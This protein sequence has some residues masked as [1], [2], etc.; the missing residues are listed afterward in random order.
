MATQI[1]YHHLVGLVGAFLTVYFY[2]GGFI[3]IELFMSPVSDDNLYISDH[4][5]KTACINR[6]DTL[7]QRRREEG[8]EGLRFHTYECI[9]QC[10]K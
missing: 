1:T 7:D 2:E 9:H 10:N 8:A 5:N 4:D 6:G 3:P